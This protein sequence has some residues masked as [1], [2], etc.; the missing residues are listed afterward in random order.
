MFFFGIFT[1]NILYVLFTVVYMVYF[2]VF[3]M[4]KPNSEEIQISANEN[5]THQI[6]IQNGG[7]T[8]NLVHCFIAKAQHFQGF[9]DF[10]H[11]ELPA[12]DHVLLP[13]ILSSDSPIRTVN[14]YFS[15]FS[16][17]PPSII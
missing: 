15:D 17:P 1:S 7:E 6:S 11:Q 2:G 8:T 9:L 3:S 5:Q 14:F 12:I 10:N 16:R 13:K 4:K